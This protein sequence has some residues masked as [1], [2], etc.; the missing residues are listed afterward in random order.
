MDVQYF[1][2]TNVSQ[3]MI[4]STNGVLTTTRSLDYERDAHTYIFSVEAVSMEN[5]TTLAMVTLI[6]WLYWA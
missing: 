1:L 5:V 6:Y 4:N 3:F 2:A